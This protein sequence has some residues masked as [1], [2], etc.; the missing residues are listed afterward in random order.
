MASAARARYK[1]SVSQNRFGTILVVL[2]VLLMLAVVS[3][4]SS[5]LQEKRDVYRSR[6]ENLESQIAAEEARTQEIEEYDKYT[7]TRKY[8]EEIAKNRLGLVYPGEIIF[9]ESK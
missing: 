2:V 7:Q 6:I 3:V 1:R 4:R 8:I 9:K 5:G